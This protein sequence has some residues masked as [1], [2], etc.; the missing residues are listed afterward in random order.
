MR[1]RIE[2]IRA[3]AD[4]KLK[5]EEYDVRLEI[6]NLRF[7]LATNQLPNVSEVRAARRKLAHIMTVMRERELA[8]EQA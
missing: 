6:M 4:D 1:G 5:E 2:Q 3:L 8:G 7:K